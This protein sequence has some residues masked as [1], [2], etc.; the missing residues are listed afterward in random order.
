MAEN[1]SKDSLLKSL[2]LN[3]LKDIVD[4]KASIIKTEIE[5]AIETRDSETKNN[6][7]D[8]F[9][10]T[11]EM[12]QLEVEK[13]MAQ[14]NKF[15]VLKNE[16]SKI[17]IY[18]YHK[19]VEYGSLVSTNENSYYISIGLGKI[20]INSKSVYCI[21]LNSPIGKILNNKKVGDEIIFQD[22]KILITGIV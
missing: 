8:K 21:S 9:E 4:E 22:K 5:L 18:K 2:I 6:A 10:T 14:L 17:D 1:I 15:E 16:L 7:G 20:E 19:C 13:N 11:R 3:R 12:M